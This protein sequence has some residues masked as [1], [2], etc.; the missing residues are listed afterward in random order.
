MSVS[1][2]IPP[3]IVAGQDNYT[4]RHFSRAY[5]RHLVLAGEMLAGTLLTLHN[6]QFFLDL[7]AQA[8]AHLDAG[9]YGA[10]HLAW[11]ERYDQAR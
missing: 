2:P 7:M 4:C 9:D 1:G 10:W 3:P 6:V 8:R 5:L 11:I